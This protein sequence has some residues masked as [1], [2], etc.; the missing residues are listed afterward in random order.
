MPPEDLQEWARTVSLPTPIPW[1][2]VE[3]RIL[4]EPG[5]TP[6]ESE[7]WARVHPE[8]GPASRVLIGAVRALVVAPVVLP[9]MG[10]SILGLGFVVAHVV[11]DRTLPQ[12]LGIVVQLIFGAALLVALFPFYTWWESRRRGWENVGLSAVSAVASTASF[13][14]LG[15]RS[16][17][18]SGDVWASV[19]WLALAAAVIAA[20]G[21]VFFLVVAKPPPRMRMGE[22][23]RK[24][25]Q[26]EKWVRARR[27]VV[28][29]ELRR[30][31]L[32][33][34][35]DSAAMVQLPMDT[36][37]QLETRPDG[38]VVRNL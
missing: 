3:S 16:P 30:R 12:D 21:L 2:Q 6:A 8:R 31:H 35:A 14:V 1:G 32:V 18:V 22:R 29:E 37:S 24:V 36:W 25:S 11:L 28:L 7:E 15:A 17:V 19:S 23:F 33:G 26:H 34:E 4:S 38:R 10:A 9:T 13:L 27:S 20:I 5:P